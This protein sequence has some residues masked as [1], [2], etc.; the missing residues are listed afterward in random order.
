MTVF[1]FDVVMIF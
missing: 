1:W